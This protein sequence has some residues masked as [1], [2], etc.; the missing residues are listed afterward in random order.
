MPFVE[1]LELCRHYLGNLV[2]VYTDWTPLTG[3]GR[4]F[5]EDLDRSQPWQFKNFRVT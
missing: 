4:L 2:G 3:R 1:I 5:A